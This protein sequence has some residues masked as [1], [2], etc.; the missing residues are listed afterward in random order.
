MSIC[1]WA[2]DLINSMGL[3]GVA[4]AGYDAG[5]FV[6]ESNPKLLHVGCPSLPY[7]VFFR[8]HTMINTRDS[9]PWSYGE[10]V[11]ASVETILNSDTNYCLISIRCFMMLP[12]RGMPVQ[13][14]L[15]IDYTHDHRVYNNLYHNQYLAGPSIL[16]A[17]AE[18]NQQL[19]KIFFPQGNWYDLY[20]CKVWSG[21]QETIVES[22]YT[23][24]S[25]IYK[26]RKCF[27]YAT[28]SRPHRS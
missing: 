9:E 12:K 25:S 22:A 26:S 1:F 8:A 3:T 20:S 10:Q 15:A 14:S 13:R 21:N 27:A 19:L 18:S 23:Q 7:P 24:T 11:R 17:P 6:G 16:V 4:F 2:F 28:F 5:G